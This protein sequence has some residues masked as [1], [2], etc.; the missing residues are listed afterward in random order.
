L[1]ANIPASRAAAMLDDR[2]KHIPDLARFDLDLALSAAV[3]DL[4]EAV[5]PAARLSFVGLS[6]HVGDRQRH[7]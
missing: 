6:H 5:L 4:V 2:V 3:L 1:L 7:D